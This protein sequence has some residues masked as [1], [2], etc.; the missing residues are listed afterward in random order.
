MKTVTMAAFILATGI[1]ASS[2][3]AQIA[4][5]KEALRAKIQDVQPV[6]EWHYD[7]IAS[8]F[9]DAKKSGKPL[10]VV[11]RCVPLKAYKDIDTKVA[12]R[13]DPK[14]AEALSQFECVRLVQIYGL[15]LGQFQFDMNQ[16]WAVLFLNADG[17]V[18]GRYGTRA[19]HEGTG[20]VSVEGLRKT[21]LAALDLHKVYASASAADKVALQKTLDAKRGPKPLWT[22]PETIP[23]IS[24]RYRPLDLR[25]PTIRGDCMWCHIAETG[26]VISAWRGGKKLGDEGVFGYPPVAVAGLRFAADEA[27]TLK[28]VDSGSPADK[29]GFRA[30]D[31]VA[32]L[33]GQPMLSEADVQFVLDKAAEPV[34]V[35]AEVQRAGQTVA[36]TLELPQGWRRGGNFIWREAIWQFRQ[37]SGFMGEVVPAA[38]RAKLGLAEKTMALRIKR[39]HGKDGQAKT[40]GL[41][42]GDVIVQVDNETG[43]WN[44]YMLLAYVFQK[45]APGEKVT[46]TVLRGGRRQQVQ[47]PLR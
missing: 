13:Q 29:A 17:T 21:C 27:S 9:T 37:I 33:D 30:G 26:R 16:V 8:G 41:R 34:K 38:E 40:A 4:P 23:S 1:M 18:Y 2:L 45:K 20:E 3:R 5:E 11:V 44:D 19:S 14:L 22:P 25:K 10:L 42:E 36:L 43:D 46:L 31:R 12:L 47:L 32:K 35:N 7:N 15:D 28:A 24:D 39:Y 6:G